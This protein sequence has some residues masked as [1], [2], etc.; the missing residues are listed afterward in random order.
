MKKQFAYM[1]GLSSLVFA[2]CLVTMSETE[3]D[4][5]AGLNG[6]F[7]TVKNGKPV[8]WMLNTN[9]TTGEGDFTWSLDTNDVKEGNQ[10][11]FCEVKACSDKGGRFSPGIAQEIPAKEG[12]EFTVSFWMKV[13]EGRFMVNLFPVSATEQSKGVVL[14]QHDV[15]ST[16][17]VH[18]TYTLKIPSN[19]NAL[20]MEFTL[21]SKGRYHLDGVQIQK[22]SLS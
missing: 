22:S 10:S 19:R 18:Y 16:E 21:L 6:G 17:W 1:L 14:T 4:T 3:T 20:R 9:A 5:A 15:T 13:E 11:L 2:S 8:N 7:E 12:D